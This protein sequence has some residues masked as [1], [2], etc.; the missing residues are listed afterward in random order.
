MRVTNIDISGLRY[1][2]TRARHEGHVSLEL[3]PSDNGVPIHVDFVCHSARAPDSPASLVTG[4]LVADALRQ[5]HR[6][7]GFRRGETKLELTLSPSRI[8]RCA[9]SA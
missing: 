2:G 6:M 7:P 4:D 9:A 1:D 3:C 5:A 8:A